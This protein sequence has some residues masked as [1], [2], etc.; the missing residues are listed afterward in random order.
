MNPLIRSKHVVYAFLLVL[1]LPVAGVLYLFVMSFFNGHVGVEQDWSTSVLAETAPLW[2]EEHTLRVVTFNIQDLLVV[3]K[4][5]EA[6]MVAIARKLGELNPQVV[7]FQESFNADH[8]ALLQEA[9][10]KHTTMSHFQ[11]YPSGRV[12]S[13]LF[14]AS[15]Y[16]IAE[17][18]F[19]RFKDSNPWYKVW[20]GD[21]WAGKGVGLARLKVGE[22]QYLDVFNTHAQADYGVPENEKIRYR[23]MEGLA[24]FVNGTAV[25][26]IP[27]LLVGDMNCKFEE[28]EYKMVVERAKLTRLM[29]IFSK[30][31]HIYGV[32]RE[33]Y[34]YT[35][36]DSVEIQETVVAGNRSFNLSDHNGYLS[37]I[38]IQPKQ[39]EKE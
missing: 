17:V 28:P 22:G 14:L 4:D 13:G 18:F 19:H 32:A 39:Q 26:H 33:E 3:A 35:V 11:Y 8:R 23:Q 27:A 6:R 12:G 31:D 9:L 15:A 30:I 24:G 25:A 1:S 36:V 16:P 21:F 38:R 10:V 29:D 7:G 5:H 34:E 2:E 37:E 20:E